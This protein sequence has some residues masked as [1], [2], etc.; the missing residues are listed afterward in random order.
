MF[1]SAPIPQPFTPDVAAP[2]PSQSA[3]ST[4]LLQSLKHLAV[5][6]TASV[7]QS[8]IPYKCMGFIINSTLLYMADVS[9]IPEEEWKIILH[10]TTETAKE[11][12]AAANGSVRENQFSMLVL[13]VLKPQEH[14]SHFGIKKAVDAARKINATR[15]YMLGFTHDLNHE[16]WVA[17][18]K[19]IES[20]N[21][22][23]K[24]LADGSL[25]QNVQTTLGLVEEGAS[26]WMRPAYDGL[27]I[28]VPEMGEDYNEV[29]ME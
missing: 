19:G 24:A 11:T 7:P 2:S 1:P 10:P 22:G 15:T 12:G 18:G 21:I 28:M 3:S 6:P 25:A 14:T 16:E 4:P 29:P 9:N 13:D 23:S 27:K 26:V 8:T 17:V 20:L 5:N